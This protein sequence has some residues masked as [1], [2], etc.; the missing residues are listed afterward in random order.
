MESYAYPGVRPKLSGAV[1]TVGT[2]DGLHLGHQKV[3]GELVRRAS[4]NHRS[5]VVVTFHP[6]P[7]WV[8]NPSTA[9]T[10][11]TT[12]EEKLRLLAQLGVDLCLIVNFTPA[13]SRLGPEEFIQ[14]LLIDFLQVEEVVV[15]PSHAF[16]QGRRGRIDYLQRMGK[17]YGFKV[18]V[19]EESSFAGFPINS[20]RIRRTISG[21]GNF[22]SALNMLGHPY[23]LDGVVIEG[24]GRG[25][26]LSLP[27]AN[28][29]FY[30]RKLLPPDGVYIVKVRW[31]GRE[32]V[33]LMNVGHRPT[34]GEGERRVEVYILGEDENFYGLSFELE[35]YRR[36]R[37][38]RFFPHPDHLQAQ[39]EKDIEETLAYFPVHLSE[40]VFR[41]ERTESI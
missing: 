27:T 10:V 11:L 14:N 37:E 40:K 1:V 34:F 35:I 26:R 39:V 12:R 15:G 9:P 24:D 22:P 18:K 13:F 17:K 23:P 19:V 29:S 32:G 16:G 20:T 25:R 7:Q 41:E 3:I 2:F 36:I 28:L 31:R 8:V 21:G 33:G 4:Y 5:S 30:F 38:E 6:H